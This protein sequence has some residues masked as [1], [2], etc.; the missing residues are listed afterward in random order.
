[1]NTLLTHENIKSF[2]F[3][4]ILIGALAVVFGA[5]QFFNSTYGMGQNLAFQMQARDSEIPIESQAQAQQ[6]FAADMSLR[7]LQSA[8]SGGVI[9]FGV[10][11]ALIGAG[12]LGRD[13]AKGRSEG[14]GKVMQ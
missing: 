2:F 3:A 9:I 13:W 6:L 14:D 4:V 5:Y 7:E 10:G 11:I 1:M 12:W 8:Q